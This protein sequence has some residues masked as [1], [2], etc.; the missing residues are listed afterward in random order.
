MR[1]FKLRQLSILPQRWN[2]S[3]DWKVGWEGNLPSSFPW[4][5]EVSSAPNPLPSLP[6]HIPYAYT[7]ALKLVCWPAPASLSLEATLT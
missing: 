7:L 3:M 4:E 5:S 6:V 1:K 2:F